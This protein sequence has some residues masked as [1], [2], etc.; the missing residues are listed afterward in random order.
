[1]SPADLDSLVIKPALQLLPAR[2]GSPEA[3]AMLIAVALQESHIKHRRQMHGGPGRG[4]WQFEPIGVRGVLEHD[5]SAELAQGVCRVLGYDAEVEE[6]YAA[7]ADNDLL[8]AC[9][10]RLLLWRSPEPLAA[11]EQGPAGWAEYL[12]LWRPG[13]PRRAR[14]ADNWASAWDCFR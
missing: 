13:K 3:R 8:A 5:A 10:A 14:W 6:V 4:F 12:H 9:F 1:M 2:M 7:V 11:R